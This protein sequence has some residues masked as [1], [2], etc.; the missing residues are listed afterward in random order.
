MLKTKPIHFKRKEKGD[1]I[2]RNMLC[3]TTLNGGDDLCCFL[4]KSCDEA[5][6]HL[7]LF[8]ESTQNNYNGERTSCK[9]FTFINLEQ[10]VKK[11]V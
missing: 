2:D 4:A 3:K 1:D 6:R 5:K 9:R 7:S 11:N 10:E 8:L